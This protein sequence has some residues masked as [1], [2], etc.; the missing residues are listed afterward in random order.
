M[1][2]SVRAYIYS[3]HHKNPQLFFSSSAS[4][5]YVCWFSFFTWM[6]HQNEP[7]YVFAWRMLKRQ[8]IWAGRTFFVLLLVLAVRSAAA[9]RSPVLAAKA[10]KQ[11]RYSVLDFH[12]AGDGKTDDA[13]VTASV[14]HSPWFWTFMLLCQISDQVFV[15]LFTIMERRSWRHGKQLAAT[16]ARLSWSS[17][18]D[19]HSCWAKS[20]FRGPASRPSPYR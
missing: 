8:G 4:S 16:A 6:F 2:P 19:G 9:A 14:T 7:S 13:P 18:E 1:R 12:A 10:R 20:G 17:L 11:G 5:W 3:S 15:L